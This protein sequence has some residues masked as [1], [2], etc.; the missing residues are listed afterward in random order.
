MR[1]WW[2]MRL[3]AD[4]ICARTAS[5]GMSIEAIITIVSRRDS[6]SLAELEWMVDMLPSWPVFMACSMSRASAPRPSPTRIRSGRIRRLLRKSCRIVS[7]PLPSTLGG[8]CSSAIT[9]GWSIC[10]SA[11]SSIV[12]TRWLCGMNRAITLRVVVLP[13]PVP[14][15]TR[16][17]IR[18]KTAASRNSAMAGLRLPSRGRSSMPSTASL[19]FR[20]GSAAARLQQ[21]VLVLESHVGF[22]QDAPTLDEDLVWA[23]DHDLAHGAVVQETVERAVTDC[24]AEDDVGQGRFFLRVE[25][26]PVLGQEAVQVRG[27]RTRERQRV[28]GG[29]ADVADQRQPVAKVVRELAQVAPGPGGGFDDV[30][31]APLRLGGCG[32]RGPHVDELHFEQGRGRSERRDHTLAFGE[33][34]LDRHALAVRRLSRVD[35]G[36]DPFAVAEAEDG[37]ARL[38]L[39]ARVRLEARVLR[40]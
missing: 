11:A 39:V 8:L 2:T 15:E 28:A 12:I 6:A 9:C 7:S 37:F 18:P 1:A 23:V 16:M 5:K 32:G 3:T 19:H 25:L 27:H 34:D 36:C 26:D 22:R 10:S 31:A 30:R 17:F 29:E 24:G 33:P 38:A 13:D 21:L 35:V 4:A 40:S 14:P 20:I